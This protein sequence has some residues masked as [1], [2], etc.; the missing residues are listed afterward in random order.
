MRGPR[1]VR[2]FCAMRFD[3]ENESLAAGERDDGARK[4]TGEGTGE[5]RDALDAYSRVVVG[6]VAQVGPAVVSVAVGS[7]TRAERARS[8]G[9]R[10]GGE[11]SGVVIAPDGYVLTNSH[12][13]HGHTDVEVSMTDGRTLAARV[14]GDDP[15]TDLALL[16]VAPSGL[17]HV[18]TGDST[19]LRAGQLVI[20]IGNPLGFQST[21]SA[22]VVSAL[23]RS[24][25]GRDGRLLESVIQHTAA[26]NP[27][28]SG[29]PLVDSRGRLVGINTAMIAT[30][31]GISFAVPA[32]TVAWVVPRLLREGRV[33]RGHLG[34][35]GRMRPIDR[36]IARVHRLTQTSGVEVLG[37]ESG[38]P[39]KR[40]GIHEGDIVIALD[41]VLVESVDDLHRA[42]TQWTP[43]AAGAASAPLRVALLRGAE[44]KEVTVLPRLV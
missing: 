20:A 32:S 22:G 30:A 23:G 8:P 21:V 31:Q 25:R 17:P 4:E 40:G 35:S 37:V 10:R 3:D 36:R 16:R 26:L 7:A 13:V 29:G 38:S 42:L 43:G 15:P 2:S 28:S 34:L 44:R 41:G 33:R 19:A 6:V 5:E 18:D 14:V 27:G 11:G 12:V 24:L 9:A 1:P 39:A